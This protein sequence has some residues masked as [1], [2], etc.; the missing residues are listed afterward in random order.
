V[1]REKTKSPFELA[2]SAARVLKANTEQPYQLFN[3]MDKMGEKV[4][5]YQ[6]L[7][8]FLIRELIG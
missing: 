1:I 6:A 4:Y 3:V 5:Y 8:G 2:I 7:Q